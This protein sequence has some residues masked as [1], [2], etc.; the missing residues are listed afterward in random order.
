M[1][2]TKRG[3]RGGKARN[4]KGPV[5]PWMAAIQ[6]ATFVILNY[7][8]DRGDT[9]NGQGNRFIG[10]LSKNRQVSVEHIEHSL[11]YLESLSSI[12]HQSEL[13]WPPMVSPPVF[14]PFQDQDTALSSVTSVLGK[15]GPVNPIKK[16][17]TTSREYQ[18]SAPRYDMAQQNAFSSLVLSDD[19]DEDDEEEDEDAGDTPIHVPLSPDAKVFVPTELDSLRLLIRVFT[20]QAD[21]YAHKARMLSMNRRWMEGAGAL[22]SAT[23]ALQNA[24]GL[25]DSEITKYLMQEVAE[26]S[27]F[28]SISMYAE[29]ARRKHQLQKDADIVHVTVQSVI[30]D[31]NQFLQLAEQ[32][33][34]RL[35]RKL[36]PQW[37]DRE[38]AKKRLGDK[39]FNNPN[40]KYQYVDA[41]KQHEK[42]LKTLQE[43]VNALAT[44]DANV[45]SVTA[46]HLKEKLRA[47]W[48]QKNRYNGKPVKKNDKRLP[49]FADPTN[50][51]WSFTG[52]SD[53]KVEF[54]EKQVA[55]EVPPGSGMVA[56][57]ILK[58]DWF[59]QTGVAKMTLEHPMQ[60]TIPLVDNVMTPAMFQMA[61][62]HPLASDL[63]GSGSPG[64]KN[65]KNCKNSFQVGQQRGKDAKSNDD[66][67]KKQKKTSPRTSATNDID[68][69]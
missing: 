3:K 14:E 27:F 32:Q 35:K 46:K 36:M 47:L 54:F 10:K 55:E 53:N 66:S 41:I 20:S 38:K 8:Y 7:K 34:E 25:A 44:Q 64:R 17:F 4:I 69:W 18:E 63:K 13:E 45:L 37:E 24:M 57:S 29:S 12:L 23:G 50:F 30:K 62:M 52:S 6:D 26:I 43:T 65:G 5:S 15:A 58:L 40:A 21:L 1:T 42:E 59:I 9:V 68:L 2:K 49:G 16:P 33:V 61:L 48:F 19:E 60:G 51:D 31:R 28:G 39:W 11:G 67:G 56:V 22:Q